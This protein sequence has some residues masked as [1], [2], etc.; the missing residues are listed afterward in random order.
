MVD[1]N[2]DSD[3]YYGLFVRAPLRARGAEAGVVENHRVVFEEGP[4]DT[5]KSREDRRP[6]F[7]GVH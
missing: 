3:W 2:P 5:A 6:F 4:Q 1:V 7:E